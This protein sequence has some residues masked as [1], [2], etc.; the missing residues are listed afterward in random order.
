M[1]TS[2]FIT[3]MASYED[4][5]SIIERITNPEEIAKTGL[6]SRLEVKETILEVAFFCTPLPSC[7]SYMEK[8]WMIQIYIRTEHIELT[9]FPYGRNKYEYSYGD[10]LD[11]EYRMNRQITFIREK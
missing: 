2:Q 9:G 6:Q 11:Y 7:K 4:R 5:P 1:D 8:K 10:R 3:K